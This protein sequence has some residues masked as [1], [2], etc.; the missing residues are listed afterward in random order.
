MTMTRK[1]VLSGMRPTGKSHLGHLHGIFKNW[2]ALQDTYECFY[3]AADWHA[4]TSEY[5]HPEIVE[6]TIWEMFVDMLSAGV[7]AGENA[8]HL[9]IQ[10]QVKEH[11]ELFLLLSMITPLGWL[12][13]NPTYKELQQELKEKEIHTFGFLG[14]PVLQAA[15]IIIYKADFVPVGKDQLPHLEITREIARR[16]NFLYGKDVFIPPDALLTDAAALGGLDGRKMSKS[17][18]NAIFLSDTVEE[19]KKKISR[20]V[21]DTRRARKSDPGEPDECNLYPFHKLYSPE[22]LQKQIA[23]D[24]RKAE[25]GCVACKKLLMDRLIDGLSPIQEKR[26]EYLAHMDDVRDIVANGTKMAR[27]ICK[28]T[29]GEVRDVLGF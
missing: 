24:C 21:T 26:R 19:I 6:A 14:Y 16:F 22:A 9:F 20:M 25:I 11:A 4:L 28:R 2:Q 17:Y 15:D 5:K 3:F 10:S 7:G 1:R 27:E 8:G 12:E 29:M 13:R 18:G 23:E